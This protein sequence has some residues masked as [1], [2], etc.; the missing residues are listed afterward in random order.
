[1]FL[2]NWYN[3]LAANI[4]TDETA[5]S[6][7]RMPALDFKGTDKHI[8]KDAYNLVALKGKAMFQPMFP[9]SAASNHY[10][11]VFGDGSVEPALNDYKL[12]GTVLLSSDASGTGTCASTMDSNA[13]EASLTGTYTIT[14]KRDT[15]IVIRE[16]GIMLEA[17][18]ATSPTG[19]LSSSYFLVER[20]LLDEPVTIPAGGFGQVVYTVKMGFP[21][22]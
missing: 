14:N 13:G 20:S 11:V 10:G 19:S 3:I 9:S 8:G 4:M 7:G 5:S 22:A 16:V 17:K 15:E 6:N 18:A 21:T 2:K 12:S 1:M